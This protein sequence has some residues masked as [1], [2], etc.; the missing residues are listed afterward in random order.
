MV[1]VWCAVCMFIWLVLCDDCFI[2]IRSLF[3]W[4]CVMTVL[5][6]TQSVWL[7][8]C[9]DCFSVIRSLFD[10]SCVKAAFDM[11]CGCLFDWSCVKVVLLMDS[12]SQSG[13][14]GG[15]PGLPE[16]CGPQPGQ[17]FPHGA[18][19][20]RWQL[21][22]GSPYRQACCCELMSFLT[23]CRMTS[24]WTHWWKPF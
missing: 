21:C 14:T 10:W 3:D 8:L 9:D 13:D 4:S 2:V 23:L 18:Q 12:C 20:G 16:A 6:D 7:V 22:C 15:D 17:Q 11:Q 19:D 5:V 24:V 1:L